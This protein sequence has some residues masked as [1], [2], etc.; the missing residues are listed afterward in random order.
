[1]IEEFG[2]GAVGADPIAP[3]KQVVNFSTVSVV[4]AHGFRPDGVNSDQESI[5]SGK[6]S[7]RGS[8]QSHYA[9]ELPGFHSSLDCAR[10]NDFRLRV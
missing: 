9:V 7:E 1:M 6:L 5:A 3:A 4:G 8:R 10:W 2:G